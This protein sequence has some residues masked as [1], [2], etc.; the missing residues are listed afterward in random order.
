MRIEAP[1]GGVDIVLGGDI[2]QMNGTLLSLRG[3]DHALALSLEINNHSQ[4]YSPKKTQLGS[5]QHSPR[6]TMG[7]AKPRPRPQHLEASGLLLVEPNFAREFTFLNR[8]VSTSGK[9]QT[10]LKS[11]E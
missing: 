3:G 6:A 11:R 1:K 8:H 9:Q 2:A 10:N 5:E 7:G 4:V